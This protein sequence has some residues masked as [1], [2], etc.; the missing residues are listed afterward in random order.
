MYYIHRKETI[1]IIKLVAGGAKPSFKISCKPQPF[2]SRSNLLHEYF[3]NEQSV[4]II[5]A[6]VFKIHS[7]ITYTLQ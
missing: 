1:G 2:F 6:I 4:I 5:M 3:Q 7:Y